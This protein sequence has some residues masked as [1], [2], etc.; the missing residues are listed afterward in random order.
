MFQDSISPEG[1][2]RETGQLEVL[3]ILLQ[4]LHRITLNNYSEYFSLASF[5]ETEK[6]E[7]TIIF[8]WL[9]ISE[10]NQAWSATLYGLQSLTE[11]LSH[12]AIVT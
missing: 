5:H 4:N 3:F 12:K 11:L 1:M 8:S 7:A 10:L 2:Q 6:V 9:A